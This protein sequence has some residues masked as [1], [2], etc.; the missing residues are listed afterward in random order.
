[1]LWQLPQLVGTRP[2]LAWLGQR[3]IGVGS[4]CLVPRVVVSWTTRTAAK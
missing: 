4:R 2:C 3:A 1:M